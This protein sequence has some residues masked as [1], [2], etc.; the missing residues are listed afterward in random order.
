MNQEVNKGAENR[1]VINLTP[2]M[3]ALNPTLRALRT[4]RTSKSTRSRLRVWRR[5]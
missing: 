5:R 4:D 1:I 3:I 2:D